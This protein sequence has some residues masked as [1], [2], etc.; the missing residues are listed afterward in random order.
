M[1]TAVVVL[2]FMAYFFAL[3][4]VVGKSIGDW[5]YNEK[6]HENRNH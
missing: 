4:H 6:N 1:W 2:I 3:V 5:M